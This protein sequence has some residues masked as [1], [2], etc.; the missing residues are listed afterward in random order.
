MESQYSAL[1]NRYC[2]NIYELLSAEYTH[3]DK[4]FVDV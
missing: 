2:V 3:E 4:A 1:I